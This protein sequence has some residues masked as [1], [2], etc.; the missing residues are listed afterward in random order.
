MSLVFG[1]VA[2]VGIF[3][4]DPHYDGIQADRVL[5]LKNDVSVF[6]AVSV[7][8]QGGEREGIRSAA[9]EIELAFR[10]RASR[11]GPSARR[12]R[13]ELTMPL[14]SGRVVIEKLFAHA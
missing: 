9:S 12:L 5:R 7:F 3:G 8:P 6:L 14:N 2:H 11:C 4:G 10:A 1:E 13:A